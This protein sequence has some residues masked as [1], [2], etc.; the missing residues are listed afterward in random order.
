MCSGGA[1]NEPCHDKSLRSFRT[2]N[3]T[4]PKRMHYHLSYRVFNVVLEVVLL[5]DH[6]DVSFKTFPDQAIA[7]YAGHLH[8]ICGS[9]AHEL[10]VICTRSVGHLH[11]NC[12][13]FAHDLWVICTR[14]V[15]HLHTI[16]GSFAHEL[17]VICTRS[18]GHFH[19]NCES[20]AHDL[21]VISTRSVGHFHT[22]CLSGLATG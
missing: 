14:T 1:Y 8:T 20:F 21:W 17:W 22:I 10:W 18:V 6:V 4:L 5:V 7:S 11:T 2:C 16:C 12:G 3:F 19:T 9:F 13:S 15:G